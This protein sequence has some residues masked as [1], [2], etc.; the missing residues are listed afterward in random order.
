MDA[1]TVAEPDGGGPGWNAPL[2]PRTQSASALNI[3]K[4]T[5]LRQN[6]HLDWIT[7]SPL[8]PKL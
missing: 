3:Y 7:M 6:K 1:G 8:R 5:C 4:C 2:L